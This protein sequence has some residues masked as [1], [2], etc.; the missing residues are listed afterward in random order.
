MK[1]SVAKLLNNYE[2]TVTKSI[3]KIP[4]VMVQ[5]SNRKIITFFLKSY[6]REQISTVLL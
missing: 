2:T 6:L 1:L 4:T 3:K 5:H